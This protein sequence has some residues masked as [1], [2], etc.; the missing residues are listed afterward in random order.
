MSNS[1]KKFDIYPKTLDDFRV[2]TI[3]GGMLSLI[4]LAFIL[5]LVLAEVRYYFKVD[6]TDELYVDTSTGEFSKKLPIFLNITFPRIP[7]NALNI[8]VMD[9]SGDHQNGVEHTL[10]KQRLD[11][12]GKFLDDK[13]IPIVPNSNTKDLEEKKEKLTA[14]LNDPKY[15]GSCYG[16]ESA[17]GQCCNTCEQVK[18]AYR[19][20]GWAFN[21]LEEIEQ[22]MGDVIERTAKYSVQE[23]CYM[24]GYFLVNKVAGNFHFAP[25]KSMQQGNQHVH[26][27]M[28]Y[29]VDHFNTSHTIQYLAFGTIYP[30]LTNPLD[31][32][33]KTVL[34]E[35]GQSGI[36]QYF[37]KVVPTIY[38]FTDG[39][40]IVTNQYSV[41]EHF[42]PRNE[43][44]PAV[45]PGVFFMYDLSPIM[46]HIKENSK[47]FAHFITSLCAIV[48][49]VFTVSSLVDT[50]LFYLVSNKTKTRPVKY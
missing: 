43:M 20:K 50:L 25:G 4:S 16:A 35:V 49:G 9:V 46:M 32:M 44:H 21:T 14:K 1:F 47:S 45:V 28:P 10:F 5:I 7:C 36:F 22:C 3:S 13:A 37:V 24:S 38:E 6:R 31:G 18:A 17:A 33:V 15:C 26:D 39:K 41:T 29:E 12:S 19:Y 27:F 48:G 2:K 30:G 23:G 40:Q 34:P 11:Y 42:R 8:D